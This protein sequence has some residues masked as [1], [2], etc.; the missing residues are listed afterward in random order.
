[1]L[2]DGLWRNQRII[3]M[4]EPFITNIQKYA[5]HDGTGIRTTVFFKGCP[6]SCRWCHNPETQRFDR[7][8]LFY[9]ERC[10]GCGA[11]V[12][13]CPEQ[14]VW[15]RDAGEGAVTAVTDGNRCRVCG[16]CEEEC[17]HGAREVCG[18]SWEIPEL[19][20]EILKDR[21]FYET[22]GG[23]VTLSGGEVLAQDMEYI[24]KLVRTLHSRGIRIFIDTCGA[25]PTERFAR[26]YPFVDTFLYDIKL[27]E[28]EKHKRYT[29]CGNR[30][31]LENL[32]WLSGQGASVW[33][34]IPVIGGV[35]DS[36][37]DMGEIGRFLKE[38]QILFKQ[39]N[40]LP[41]HDT[42]S[43]KYQHLGR[44]YKK[45]EFYV[46]SEEKMQELKHILEQMGLGPVLIG[47]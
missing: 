33:I 6:L 4:K 24:E 38:N 39:I 47:G 28:E 21:A 16:I 25:V 23:G 9:Q 26:I 43:G 7:T 44:E 13:A 17:I 8:M 3:R 34:R 32:K 19:V 2:R 10:A 36:E 35:N 11:C 42:G 37:A 1:M 12:R 18:K 40:L 5:I 27:M 30:Q 20:K 22:S 31:I 29:G 15:M 46:P 14:A 41:Y 45:E